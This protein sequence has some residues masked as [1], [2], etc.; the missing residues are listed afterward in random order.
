M[1]DADGYCWMDVPWGLSN[2]IPGEPQ[3]T[4]PVKLTLVG[5]WVQMPADPGG[6]EGE[7]GVTQSGMMSG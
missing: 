4:G 2:K 6:R 1:G 3:F 7:T 5:R